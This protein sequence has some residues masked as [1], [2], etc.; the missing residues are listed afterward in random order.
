MGGLASGMDIDSIVAKL[1]S[2]EKA[3]LNKLQQQKQKYEWQR[4]AYREVNTSLKKA[5][6][7]MANNVLLVKDFWKKNVTSTNSAVSATNI[8]AAEGATLNIS[9][10]SK[11][12][13][14]GK[15][16]SSSI[17]ENTSKS[18]K[19][20]DLG[21]AGDANGN[22]EIKLN[23]MDKEGN[24]KEVTK[25]FKA[26][27]TIDKVIT[28]L[29]NGTGLNAFYDEVSGKMSIMTNATGKGYV[30]KETKYDPMMD[31]DK[32]ITHSNVGAHI[33]SGGELFQ[34]LGFNKSVLVEGGENAQLEVNGL[35]IERKSN[36]FEVNGFSVTLNDTYNVDGSNTKPIT[37]ATSTDVDHMVNKIKEF[38]TSYNELIDTLKGKSTETKYRDYQPLTDEQR[39]EMDKEDIEKWE[40]KAKSGVLRGDSILRNG[41]NSLRSVLSQKGGS[42][43]A[44]IN[45]LY[46]LGITTTKSYNDGGKLEILDEAKLREAI[47]KDPE[48]VMKTFS[49]SADDNGIVQKLRK[50]ITNIT[51]AIDKKAGRST[52]TEHTYTIGKNILN[53]DDRISNWKTKLENIEERYWKQ[54]TAMETAI[55]KANQQSSIFATGQ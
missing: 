8:S 41:L 26:T 1:M 43:N 7:F 17:G 20:A 40:E 52:M 10:V 38:V 19:L 24:P 29:N 12:A 13:T 27:D 32:T 5:D 30:Y 18:T 22:I 50:E 51:T 4:D 15:S 47:T 55:N 35:Q 16:V 9:K 45:S 33:V 39:E 3:P 6:T 54:F 42:S 2:A 25:S 49:N 46:S 44:D 34:A 23:V 53:V 14:A 21:L 37:I 31:E 48:A 36:T 28:E 11:L